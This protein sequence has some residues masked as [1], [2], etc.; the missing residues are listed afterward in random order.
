MTLTAALEHLKEHASPQYLAGMSRFGID[1]SKALGVKLPVIRK[2]AKVIKKDQQLSLELWATDIHEARLLA[3]MIGDPAQVSPQQMDTW[4]GDFST[5]D[6]CDQACGNLF[7]RTP[8]VLDKIREYCTSD[9]EFV[10][11]CG[12]VLMAEYAV[13]LK[14]ATDD[15]FL[16]FL[17]II[18]REA[19]DNRN[20]VKKAINWAL[21]QIGKRNTLLKHTAIDTADRILEQDIKAARWIAKDALRELHNR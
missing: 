2:L 4:A 8:F 7:I 11:R 5:W 19:W 3:T 17:P 9:Q 10:K 6:V 14:K 15:V 18:E 13:H 21:R 20:F 16:S 12:F 1:N